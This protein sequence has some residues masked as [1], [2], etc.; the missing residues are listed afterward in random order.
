M[1]WQ[2]AAG[3]PQESNRQRALAAVE[4][5]V[6][7][8]TWFCVFL[9][10]SP[11]MSRL[12]LAGTLVLLALH[13]AEAQDT[14]DTYSYY[15]L[16]EQCAGTPNRVDS[17]TQGFYDQFLACENSCNDSS[18]SWKSYNTVCDSADYKADVATAF[19][20]SSYLLIEA[21]TDDCTQFAG[22]SAFV[23]SAKCEQVIMYVTE[24]GFSTYEKIELQSNGS[25]FV[26]YFRDQDCTTP[27]DGMVGLTF[28]I[29]ITDTDVDKALL[30]SNSCDTDGYRWTYVAGASSGSSS[31]SSVS[32]SG[33]DKSGSGSIS[34]STASS[35]SSSNVGIIAGS[36]GGVVL[37]IL[38]VLAFIFY[39]RRSHGKQSSLNTYSSG[40]TQQ[41]RTSSLTVNDEDL[42]GQV[43]LWGDDVITAKRIPRRDVQIKQM[44]SRGAFGEVY[45][46][47]FEETR[48]AVK[49]LSPETRSTISYVNS[50]LAEAKMTATMD[51]PH[52][53][54]FIGVAWKSLSDLCI[55]MEFMEGGD[56]RSL[57]NK[58]ESSGHP[59]G[60]DRQKATIAL[61]VCHALTYL[62][63]LSPPVIHRDLKSRNILLTRTLE[64]KLTDF[65]ISRERLDQTM[66]AGVV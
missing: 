28:Q 43:G 66:T 34:T 3:F 35:S 33:S 17:Y 59:Q 55:V 1:K 45:E 60:I 15:S 31:S 47:I 42:R 6:S 8:H 52:I 2:V 64:A 32:S 9:I 18:S 14:Y 11:R 49:I 16:R 5:N 48:V 51:H 4:R 53:V 12:G 23:A 13:P 50:F 40:T 61:Q 57:L 26:R 22:S 24:W 25:L 37:I 29:N 20:N 63:S 38:I 19:G 36:I 41:Q 10:N 54:A 7:A 56:L 39:R 30:N 62:H 65:G 27:L 44:I 21:Y 58:Y 46:G